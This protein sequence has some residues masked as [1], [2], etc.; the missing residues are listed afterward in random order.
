MKDFDKKYKKWKKK[1]DKNKNLPVHVGPAYG[2]LD[3]DTIDVY[4]R[5]VF[6]RTVR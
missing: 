3:K 4:Y 5:Y 6:S 2:K 1:I